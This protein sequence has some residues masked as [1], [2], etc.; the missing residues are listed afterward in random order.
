MGPASRVGGIAG[1]V[2]AEALAAASP[3][4]PHREPGGRRAIIQNNRIAHRIGE[5][6]LTAGI[7]DA[8]KGSATVGGDRRTRYVDG[9]GVA[10]SRVVV[11]HNN[12][13]GIIRISP[14][15]CL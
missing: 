2:S 10:A 13:L 14:R 4:Q 5:G 9:T 12:L 8:G 15:E 1:F 11:G 3:I 7:G 6:T